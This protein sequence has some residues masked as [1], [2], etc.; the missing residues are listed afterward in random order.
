MNYTLSFWDR[1]ENI[2]RYSVR[3]D[4]NS[5]ERM[6]RTVKLG[7][8]NWITSGSAEGA[9]ASALMYSIVETAKLHGLDPR[10]YLAYLFMYGAKIA[11]VEIPAKDLEPILPWNIDRSL[12]GVVDDETTRRRSSR[13]SAPRSP[14]ISS[15]RNRQPSFSFDLP[16][17]RT[18]YRMGD[19]SHTV[20]LL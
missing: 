9:E 7:A 16:L 3:L 13:A 10:K 8:K 15:E 5:S 14:R 6:A 17:T 18:A 11:D 19:H 2:Y 1:I 12:L 20:W 4:N